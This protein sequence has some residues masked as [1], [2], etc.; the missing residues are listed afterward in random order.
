VIFKQAL[1]RL[2]LFTRVAHGGGG[3][4]LQPKKKERAAKWEIKPQ[5]KMEQQKARV[6]ACLIFCF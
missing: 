2:C 6:R 1:A 5:V 3:F 4:A